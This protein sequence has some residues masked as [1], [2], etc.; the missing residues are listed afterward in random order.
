LLAVARSEWLLGLLLAIALSAGMHTMVHPHRRMAPSSANTTQTQSEIT[1]KY[2]LPHPK[3]K[4]NK[5]VK[6]TA[7]RTC[8]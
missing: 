3:S 2:A 4:G 7:T 5:K 1:K 8:L 6:T